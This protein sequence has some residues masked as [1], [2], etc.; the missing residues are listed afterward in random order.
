MLQV[1]YLYLLLV[2]N[3]YP[4][5][6]KLTAFK[7]NCKIAFKKKMQ[8]EVFALFYRKTLEKLASKPMM[9]GSL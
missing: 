3:L 4:L 9:E 6:P 8:D 1:S 7:K 2:Y 5:L